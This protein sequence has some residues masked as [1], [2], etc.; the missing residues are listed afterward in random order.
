MKPNFTAVA[1]IFN[2]IKV[3]YH[4]LVDNIASKINIFRNFKQSNIDLGLYHLMHGNINDAIFRFYVISRFIDP[5]DKKS[6][7]LLSWSYFIKGDL[8]RSLQELKSINDRDS[9]ELQQYINEYNSICIIPK[10]IIDRYTDFTIE[11]IYNRY[12]S[13]DVSLSR[14]MLTMILEYLVNMPKNCK[15]LDLGCKGGAIGAEFNNILDQ[16][17]YIKGVESN[18]SLAELS[19]HIAQDNRRIYDDIVQK[20]IN[21]FLNSKHTTQYNIITCFDSLSF[22]KDL[23]SI[24]VGISRV[25]NNGGIL[26][27]LLEKSAGHTSIANDYVSFKFSQSDVESQLRLAKFSISNIKSTIIKEKSYFLIIAIK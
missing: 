3:P 5:Q 24:F 22:T 17:F 11:C 12:F 23:R 8:K 6:K 9:V 18:K 27:I 25:L 10:E 4:D 21:D 26:A 20:D 15:I 1:K 7:N 16:N 2:L 13:K 14:V 19:K